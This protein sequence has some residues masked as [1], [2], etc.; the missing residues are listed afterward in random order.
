ML[1]AGRSSTHEPKLTTVRATDLDRPP[2]PL[3]N[4]RREQA[5]VL[6][7]FPTIHLSK[8]ISAWS[9]HASV[10]Q[11]APIS[12]HRRLATIVVTQGPLSVRKDTSSRRREG[13]S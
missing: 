8:N 6:V 2:P 10:A 3:Y 13:Q 4:R 9:H 12:N 1:Q 5:H 7:A 11:S